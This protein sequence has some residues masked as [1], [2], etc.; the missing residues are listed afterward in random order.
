MSRSMKTKTIIVSSGI[1]SYGVRTNILTMMRA[2][3]KLGY[4]TAFVGFTKGEFFETLAQEGFETRLT[5]FPDPAEYHGVVK[6]LQNFSHARKHRFR[7]AELL[8]QMRG[9]AVIVRQPR[10]VPLVAAASAEAKIPG[11]WLMPN[12]V[13]DRYPLQL[14][15]RLY[16]LILHRSG[17]VA[18]A[19]SHATARSLFKGK[20]QVRVAHLGMSPER[21]DPNLAPSIT[22][23]RFGFADGDAVFSIFARLLPFKGQRI[24]LE[25][26]ASLAGRYPEIRLLIVGGPLDSSFAAELRSAIISHGLTGR[27]VL[28]GTAAELGIPIPDLYAISDVVVNCRL[29]PEPFGLSVIEGMLMSKPLLVHASGGPSETVLDGVDGWHMSLP[30]VDAF[31][32]GIVRAVE[33]RP[34]W[35][36]IGANARHHALEEFTDEKFVLRLIKILGLDN[37]T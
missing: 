25:A 7:L 6:T 26:F 18:V 10:F 14:N 9:G 5:E 16:D 32:Q 29:D 27:V 34:Q 36:E 24:F 13:S 20:A 2:L 3:R 11:Y 19:N 22:K 35:R 15:G 17:M 23:T 30:T 1:D 8:T 37:S 28:A 12:F 4:P 31:R 33:A 21:F